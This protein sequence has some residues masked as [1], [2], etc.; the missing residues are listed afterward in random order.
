MDMVAATENSGVNADGGGKYMHISID[1]ASMALIRLMAA[2]R[3]RHVVR[4]GGATI[5]RGIGRCGG[6]A[7]G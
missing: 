1:V 2:P 3:R 7:E 4:R 6:D 5:V